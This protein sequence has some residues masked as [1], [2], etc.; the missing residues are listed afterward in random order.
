M[1]LQQIAETHPRWG[2]NKMRDKLKLKGY[3]WNHK[4]V[5]RLY[6]ELKLNLRIKP[7]KRLPAREPKIL[8]QP[9]R[10]NFCWSMDFMSD[11]LHSGRKFRTLN[12][13]DDYNREALLIEAGF[14]ISSLMVVRCLNQLASIRGYPEM[15]RVDNGPEFISKALKEWAIKH[16]VIIHYIQPGKPSQNA[17]IERFNR[18]FRTEILDA[19]WF[20][21][22]KEVRLISI[23]WLKQYNFERPHE[24]LAG[25]APMQFAKDR[26]EGLTSMTQMCQLVAPKDSGFSTFN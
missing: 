11:A 22:M 12:I 24:S 18:T 25:K 20:D 2:F 16:N 14:S 8:L 13:I 6:R 3:L 7:K 19:Y 10:A 5:Y 17:F 4:R 21:T 23:E 15:I 26:E 9:L 1:A